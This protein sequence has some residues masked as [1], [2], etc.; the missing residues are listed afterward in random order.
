MFETAPHDRKIGKAS[1]TMKKETPPSRGHLHFCCSLYNL[2]DTSNQFQK[3]FATGALAASFIGVCVYVVTCLL[4]FYLLSFLG[5]SAEQQRSNMI[6]KTPLDQE[7]HCRKEP[8]RKTI[9]KTPFG[10]HSSSAMGWRSSE[11]ACWDLSSCMT[12]FNRWASSWLSPCGGGFLR[13][14][15]PASQQSAVVEPS[16]PWCVSGWLEPRACRSR[17]SR[18]GSIPSSIPVPNTRTFLQSPVE[19]L[20]TCTASPCWNPAL[21]WPF[22][23]VLQSSCSK[24]GHCQWKRTLYG[25]IQLLAAECSVSQSKTVVLQTNLEESSKNSDSINPV[26][27]TIESSH[28]NDTRTIH[29]SN[30][31]IKENT[32]YI[33][34]KS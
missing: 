30:I 18:V 1:R 7:K 4:H 28:K 8:S 17:R 11:L 23:P 33:S 14:F 19:L 22:I 12:S 20:H 9:W 26:S 34:L 31:K 29:L 5:W 16:T 27:I 25:F 3:P 6:G 10:C 2:R 15:L 24:T 21:Q 13:S 32:L